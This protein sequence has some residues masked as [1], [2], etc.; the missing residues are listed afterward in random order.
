[1][2][3]SI[4]VATSALQTVMA[5]GMSHTFTVPLFANSLP[6]VQVTSSTSCPMGSPTGAFCGS[7]TLIVPASNPSVGTISAGT[8]TFT[9]PAS[10]DVLYTVEADATNP[11]SNA[12]ICSPSSQTTSKDSNN[13]PLKVTP[14]AMVSAA[15]IDFSACM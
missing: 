15:R 5:S 1:M 9:A 12:A 11:T 3:A 10:G 7:Y 4:D 2:G 8:V 6:A 14:G 13:M